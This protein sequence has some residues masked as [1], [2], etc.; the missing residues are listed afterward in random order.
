[1]RHNPLKP[2]KGWLTGDI[3]RHA[4]LG[5][6]KVTPR[7]KGSFGFTASG[8]KGYKSCKPTDIKPINRKDGYTYSF[9]A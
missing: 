2:I 8:E 5:I 1:M 3:A 7:S 4:K 6:G 9:S